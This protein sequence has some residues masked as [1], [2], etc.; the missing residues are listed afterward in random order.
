MPT[1]DYSCKKCG[2][3]EWVQKMSEKALTRCPKCGSTDIKRH[4]GSGCGI[5][6]KGT[7]F[8]ET[9]YKRKAVTGPGPSKKKEDKPSI[10]KSSD[11]KE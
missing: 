4:V 6:F 1:Y 10:A 9:D 3:F 8:Y 7:G 2:M 11:G 5:I